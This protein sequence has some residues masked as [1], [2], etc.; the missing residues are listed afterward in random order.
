MEFV[1]GLLPL[2]AQDP[3]LDKAKLFV[4]DAAR[5][6]TLRVGE[7]GK[8][9]VTVTEER[10]GKK[11]KK[12]YSA[13]SA[14]EFYK[15][16]PEA[17]VRHGLGRYLHSAA[18]RGG[19][20]PQD[21]ESWWGDWKRKW[22]IPEPRFFDPFGDED[23]ERFFEDPDD[24]FDELRQRL[25]P[26]PMPAPLPHLEGG[27]PAG[28]EL[29]IM[30]DGVD[31]TLR[32]HL[33]LKEKEGLAVIDIKPGSAAERAGLMVHDVVLKVDGKAVGDRMQFRKDVQEA[34]A[35]PEFSLDIVRGGKRETV[36]VAPDAKKPEKK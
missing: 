30:V 6:M 3:G 25:W 32:E 31:E 19:I 11:E 9:D 5:G 12:T 7:D 4:Y 14:E 20:G 29:G 33:G 2:F 35:K 8:V 24:L 36:K 1:L 28:P 27:K 15:K 13:A 21:F 10:E 23:V 22:R 16:H 34:L 18:P 17:V 26:L